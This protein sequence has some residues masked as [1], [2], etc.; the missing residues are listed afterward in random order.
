MAEVGTLGAAID[1]AVFAALLVP[2]IILVMTVRR[3]RGKFANIFLLV[4][5]G[6]VPMAAYHL[7][8][9]FGYL[10]PDVIPP[11][12]VPYSR[13]MESIVKIMGILAIGGYMYW[14]YREYAVTFCYLEKVE[15][16]EKKK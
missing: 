9:A 15:K 2:I 10:E 1:I 14:F 6:L 3:C 7:L 5:I 4:I 11:C 8:K 13:V 16:R 12:D